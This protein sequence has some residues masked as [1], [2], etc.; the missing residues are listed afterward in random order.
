MFCTITVSKEKK[1]ACV[2]LLKLLGSIIVFWENVY[3]S[4]LHVVYILTFI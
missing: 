4:I 3:S 1:S 2:L